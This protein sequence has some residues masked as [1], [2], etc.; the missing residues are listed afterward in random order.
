MSQWLVNNVDDDKCD[1]DGGLASAYTID[2]GNFIISLQ[3][4]SL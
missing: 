2:I 1:D 4:K 3:R